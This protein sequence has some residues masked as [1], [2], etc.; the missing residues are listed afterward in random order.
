MNAVSND[1][2]GWFPGE[3]SL[4]RLVFLVFPGK[5]LLFCPKMQHIYMIAFLSTPEAYEYINAAI[6]SRLRDG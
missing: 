1:S 6:R 2:D 4:S 3:Q 5:V